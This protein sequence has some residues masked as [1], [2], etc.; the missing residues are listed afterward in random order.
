MPSDYPHGDACPENDR[1]DLKSDAVQVS[2][3]LPPV[4]IDGQ[5]VR[6]VA[7]GETTRS[8]IPVLTVLGTACSSGGDS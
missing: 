4:V 6:F 1:S 5:P 3:D 2:G 7:T 8:G